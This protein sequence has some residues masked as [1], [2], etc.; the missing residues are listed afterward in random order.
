MAEENPKPA[1]GRSK[2]TDDATS[3][4]QR[5]LYDCAYMG[6]LKGVR[7]ALEQGANVDGWHEQTGLNA[8][9]LAVGTNNLL[10]VKY[11]LE[12]AGAELVPDRSGRWPTVIAAECSADEELCDY[13]VEQEAKLLKS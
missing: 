1:A 10:L 2:L 7:T 8:L 13:I 12:T 9:H 4:V 5:D 6:D 3:R 11:L